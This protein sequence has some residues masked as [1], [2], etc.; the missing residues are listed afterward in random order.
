M[1]D[2]CIRQ[3]LLD[4]FIRYTRIDTQSSLERADSGMQ[5][6][7]EGQRKLAELLQT[8]LASL[9]ISDTTITE[10]GYL[11][12][13]I[14]AT[15]GQEKIPPFGL[16][17]HLDTALDAPGNDVKAR[18]H[19]NYDGSIITVGNGYVL[20]PAENP[21]LAECVGHTIITSDGTT[22][23]G[24]DNKA[25]IA[26]I[27]TLISQLDTTETEHGP[28]EIV[29][30]P[31]EETGHGM[32]RIPLE[33]IQ[34]KAFYTVD[35]G[36]EGEIEIECFNAWK[37]DLA[38]TGISAHPGTARGKMVNAVTM[39]AAF[40]Q[41]LPARESPEVT[42]GYEGFF[43]PLEIHG[44][45]ENATLSVYVRDFDL[46]VMEQRLKRITLLAEAAEAQFPGGSVTVKQTR[47]YLNMKE[48]LDQAPYVVD[49]LKTAALRAGIT[50][51]MTPI[52]GGTDGS[53]LTEMGIPTPNIFT[54]GHNFHSRTEWASLEQMT[55]M[56]KTLVEL[57][58]SWRE[59]HV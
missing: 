1:N 46:S 34:S 41:A 21:E 51:R 2:Q 40:V 20:D 54:G 45:C 4:R 44:S 25:G 7:S 55:A 29:F 37:C 31:D 16:C 17:A 58:R 8:E 38:F 28:L 42:S 35:G 13:R 23:L 57:T 39:A 30:S 27:M 53:R 15:R 32:D 43:Y 36:R 50:I 48:K 24:A 52:R 33:E 10:Y 3:E 59:Y 12:A 56:V 14:P 26:G 6:S 19:E 11:L 5:P 22:L 18:I 49:V 47:Q 9:G